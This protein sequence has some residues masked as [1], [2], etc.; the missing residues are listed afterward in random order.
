VTWSPSCARFA[1]EATSTTSRSA[2]YR[3]A[4]SSSGLRAV[5]LAEMLMT[6]APPSTAARMPAAMRSG[7][8]TPGPSSPTEVPQRIGRIV[9]SGATPAKPVPSR[10]CAAMIP[11]T[12]VP[13]P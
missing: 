2:A 9:T 10:A 7:V 12:N 5:V 4:A 13:W 6:W 3:T 1:A 8:S 11:A